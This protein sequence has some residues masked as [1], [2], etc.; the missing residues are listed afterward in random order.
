MMDSEQYQILQVGGE[1]AFSKIMGIPF[2]ECLEGRGLQILPSGLKVLVITKQS[3]NARLAVTPEDLAL[4]PDFVA[5]MTG[6]GREFRFLGMFDAD[7][8]KVG[9]QELN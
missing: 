4:K 8:F 3:A 5:I 2:V 7:D 1:M 6:K 9:A